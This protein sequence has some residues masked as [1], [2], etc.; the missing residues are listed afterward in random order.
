MQVSNL[1][2]NATLATATE[3]GTSTVAR[4]HDGVLLSP[5]E[6]TTLAGLPA[7]TYMYQATIDGNPLNVLKTWTVKGGKA[8]S[9]TYKAGYGG[10]TATDLNN[11]FD[12]YLTTAQQMVDSLQT[13]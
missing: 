2:S 9:I 5:E 12:K 4:Y 7:K 1:P 6:N 11:I 3:N 8:Y 13:K 10:G